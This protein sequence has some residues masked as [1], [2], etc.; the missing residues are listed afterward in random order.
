ML[1]D[2]AVVVLDGF[3]PFELGVVCEVFGTDRTDEGLPGYDFAVVAGEPGPLRSEAGFVLQTSFGLDRLETAD[4]I[5][6][7]ASG[8]SRCR[9]DD[10]PEPLLDALRRAVD[11]GSRVL[12]VCTGHSRSVRRDYSTG[13][14][15]RRTGGTRSG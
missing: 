13:E 12:S 3:T 15:A 5:A 6:V 11:R 8:D 7:P 14:P 10:W 1:K 2:V 4:L 9:R